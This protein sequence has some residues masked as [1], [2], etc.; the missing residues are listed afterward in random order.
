MTHITRHAGNR[1]DKGDKTG[2]R[3]VLSQVEIIERMGGEDSI[4]VGSETFFWS[5]R[6]DCCLMAITKRQGKV[7][8]TVYEPD[9]G[10][11]PWMPM[12]TKFFRLQQS[13]FKASEVASRN[14]LEAVA[15][16]L[17]DRKPNEA[18]EDAKRLTEMMVLYYDF[19]TPRCT[20]FWTKDFHECVS[21]LIS[22]YIREHEPSASR[23]KRLYLQVCGNGWAFLCPGYV[24]FKL[25]Q[26]D[27]P[28]E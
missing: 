14:P 16:Y 25:L 24:P 18:I 5:E 10:Y 3:T 20:T 23:K 2:L 1:I 27:S 28:L 15:L 12:I 9:K 6:D 8:V 21:S 19:P 22:Q 11:A 13:V 17:V 7:L 4:K 26:I